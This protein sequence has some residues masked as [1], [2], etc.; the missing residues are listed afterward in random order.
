MMKFPTEFGVGSVKGSQEMARKANLSVYR[1]RESKEGHQLCA[2]LPSGRETR[3]S[4]DQD[5]APE[6]FELDP[7]EGPEDKKDEPT[8][9]VILDD[10]EPTRVVKIGSNL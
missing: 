9:D 7:R 2:I 3:I 5:E 10:N 1:D 4:D 6:E 8:E